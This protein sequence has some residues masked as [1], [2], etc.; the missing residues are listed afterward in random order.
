MLKKK[1]LKEIV[2]IDFGISKIFKKD[3]STYILGYTPNYCAPE[4]ITSNKVKI[5]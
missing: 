3:Q 4:L 2:L 1:D 5:N